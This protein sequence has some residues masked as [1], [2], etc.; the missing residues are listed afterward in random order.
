MVEWEKYDEK[1]HKVYESLKEIFQDL[2]VFKDENMDMTDFISSYE[3]QFLKL[4]FSIHVNQ[5]GNNIIL[6]SDLIESPRN[7]KLVRQC[8]GLILNKKSEIKCHPVERFYSHQDHHVAKVD[9][10]SSKVFYNFD[11]ILIN[12]YFDGEWKFSS[13]NELGNSKV[14]KKFETIFKENFNLPEE[15]NLTFVFT[16]QKEDS[17]I[18]RHEYIY[19]FA[20]K[21][22]REMETSF[23][24]NKYKWNEIPILHK[25]I[26]N[27]D[28]LFSIAFSLDPLQHSGFIVMDKEFNRL[29]IDS[30]T[31]RS[32]KNL[33]K[34]KNENF[35]M[36]DLIRSDPNPE[37]KKLITLNIQQKYT[38]FIDFLQ[39]NYDSLVDLDFKS[40]SKKVN[41]EEYKKLF[42]KMKKLN[43]SN[44]KNYLKTSSTKEIEIL[45]EKFE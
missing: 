23:F 43:V 36:L 12:L 16:F 2:V 44:V 26:K 10:K 18:K 14:L 7:Y 4:Y 20:V 38:K 29:F 17:F 19:L 3:I 11:F 21:N 27:L 30:S 24:V 5:S 1:Y 39:M 9:L 35:S 13:R 28:F 6:T 40:F 32:Y 8:E 34:G 33:Q 37:V 41:N 31:F 42:L 45:F 22:E 15:Q 25:S